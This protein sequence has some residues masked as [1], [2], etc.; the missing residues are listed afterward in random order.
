MAHP[1]IVAIKELLSA[2]S[3]PRH[4]DGE[5]DPDNLIATP[6]N[7]I[8]LAPILSRLRQSDNY[9]GINY[10]AVMYIFF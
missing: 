6:R 5:V 10:C 3:L 8:R 1:E 7:S 9:E 4:A 2:L